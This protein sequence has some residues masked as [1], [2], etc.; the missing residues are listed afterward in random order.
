MRQPGT[1]AKQIKGPEEE[2]QQGKGG[3]EERTKDSRFG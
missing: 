2:K 3:F 1:A